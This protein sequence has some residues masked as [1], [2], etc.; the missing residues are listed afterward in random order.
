MLSSAFPSLCS[1]EC[2]SEIKKRAALERGSL[3]RKNRKLSYWNHIH[4]VASASATEFNCSCCKSEECVIFAATYI[5]T[6]VKLCST[7]ANKNFAAVNNL[8]TEALN[9]EVLR[10]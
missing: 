8:T 10:V 3:F 4:Y 7:L 9:A 2:F 1:V 5:C 6:R